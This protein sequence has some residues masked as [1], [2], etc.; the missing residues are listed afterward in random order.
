MA[1]SESSTNENIFCF[2]H[3]DVKH[4]NSYEEFRYK[5]YSF[6]I[7]YIYSIHDIQQYKSLLISVPV[8]ADT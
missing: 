8:K 4:L 5:S 1:W 2:E 3:L 7:D 6:P